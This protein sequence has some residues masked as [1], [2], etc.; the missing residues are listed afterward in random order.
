MSDGLRTEIL[1]ALADADL[2]GSLATE[3]FESVL[4][5]TMNSFLAR[6]MITSWEWK[7][8]TCHGKCEYYVG[9]SLHASNPSVWLRVPMEFMFPGGFEIMEVM[10]S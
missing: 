2:A 9:S 6:R 8:S 3:R 10:W 7:T 5:K 4:R 1:K